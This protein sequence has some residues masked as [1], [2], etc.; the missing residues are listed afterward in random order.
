M[1]GM[2]AEQNF[3]KPPFFRAEPNYDWRIKEWR[4]EG[5]GGSH[6]VGVPF[7]KPLRHSVTKENYATLFKFQTLLIL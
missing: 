4:G 2:N 7:S 3:K 5:G 6:T 1:N